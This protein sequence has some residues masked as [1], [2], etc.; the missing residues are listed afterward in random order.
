MFPDYIP[1]ILI[2]DSNSPSYFNFTVSRFRKKLKMRMCV[3]AADAVDPFLTHEAGG[4]VL[5]CA[6]QC[7]YKVQA[8]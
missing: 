4:T 7:L 1:V 6:V 3:Y 2:L 5:C 8:L